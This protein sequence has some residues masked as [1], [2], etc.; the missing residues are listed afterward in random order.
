MATPIVQVNRLNRNQ[1]PF[2]EVERF[3]ASLVW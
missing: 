1:G 3:F 2:K